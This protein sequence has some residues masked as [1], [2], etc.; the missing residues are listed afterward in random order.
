MQSTATYRWDELVRREVRCTDGASLG[1]IKQIGPG[2]VMTER[3][4][5][6]EM[7]R[8][9]LPKALV[10]GFDGNVVRFNV[11]E[12]QAEKDFMKTSEPKPDEYDIYRTKD[13]PAGLDISVSSIYG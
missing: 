9:Y 8:F 11:T 1:L 2:W 6:K 12:E 10:N 4:N 13:T 5:E 3:V 7:S